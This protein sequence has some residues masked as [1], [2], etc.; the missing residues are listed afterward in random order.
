MP[1]MIEEE[2][3]MTKD[4]AAAHFKVST[5]KIKVTV[6]EHGLEQKQDELDKRKYLV[7]LTDLQK[8]YGR[9]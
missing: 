3:W 6:R 2:T 9:E 7:R 8:V 4:E 5:Q 1:A